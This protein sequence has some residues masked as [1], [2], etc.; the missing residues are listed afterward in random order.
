MYSF[1]FRLQQTEDIGYTISLSN[2]L[3]QWKII[4]GG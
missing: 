4:Q 3:H 1:R 2:L